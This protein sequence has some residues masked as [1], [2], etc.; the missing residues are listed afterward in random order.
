MDPIRVV[1]ADDEPYTRAALRQWLG[2]SDDLQIVGEAEDGSQ[3]LEIVQTTPADVLVLDLAMPRL[4][5]MDVL[6]KIRAVSPRT[7]VVVFSAHAS[8]LF[9]S[10]EACTAAFAFLEKGVSADEIIRTV[11]IAAGR[12]A[13]PAV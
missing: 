3:A 10:E 7:R 6:Q 8:R 5:G 1:I 9:E 2:G 12:A 13:K 11:R 4:S